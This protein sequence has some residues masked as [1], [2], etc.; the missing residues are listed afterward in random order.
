MVEIRDFSHFYGVVAW[1]GITETSK[2]ICWNVWLEIT[3]LWELLSQQ[4]PAAVSIEIAGAPAQIVNHNNI[5]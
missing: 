1:L 4:E 2:I 5:A 3:A